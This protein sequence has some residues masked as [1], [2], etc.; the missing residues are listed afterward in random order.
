MNHL[1]LLAIGVA[2]VGVLFVYLLGRI[3]PKGRW[4]L[5]AGFLGAALGNPLFQTLACFTVFSLRRI[6]NKS[7]NVSELDAAVFLAL[8]GM[9]FVVRVAVIIIL[10]SMGGDKTD[11]LGDRIGKSVGYYFHMNAGLVVGLV[12]LFFML[13]P[14]EGN[15]FGFIYMP[16]CAVTSSVA[17]IFEIF[18]FGSL[19]KALEKD[20]MCGTPS[21]PVQKILAV[22]VLS[23]AILIIAAVPVMFIKYSPVVSSVMKYLATLRRWMT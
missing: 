20:S 23:L 1:K 8:L 9:M 15:V 13:S 16:I 7:G 10:G 14:I 12:G 3:L 2:V 17:L 5:L 19:F 21:V 11:S 18:V 6:H 4:S 22:W